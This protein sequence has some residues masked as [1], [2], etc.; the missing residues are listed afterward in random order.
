MKV[1]LNAKYIIGEFVVVKTT[2]PVDKST[3]LL[4]R[5]GDDVIKATV[6]IPENSPPAGFVLIKNWSENE[7]LLQE[8][9]NAKVVED[10][11]ITVPTG[12]VE[13]NLCKLLADV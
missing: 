2:Y 3:C 7:G 6:C 13:A 11:R 12:F 1:S 8:L 10:T 9:V 4:L 5:N